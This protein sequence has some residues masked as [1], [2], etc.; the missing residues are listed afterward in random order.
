[1]GCSSAGTVNDVYT[2]LDSE[3]VRKRTDFFTDTISIFCI[4]EYGGGDNAVTLNGIVRQI[5]LYNPRTD[6][7]EETNRVL[8][9]EELVPGKGSTRKLAV[10]FTKLDGKGAT[11]LG[12][13]FPYPAGNF[14]C[15]VSLDGKPAG[16]YPFT[17]RFAPCPDGVVLPGSGCAGFYKTND[18]CPKYGLTSKDPSKVVCD[19]ATGNWKDL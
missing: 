3:G 13:Q 2:A 17:V 19:G 12:A 18:S 10:P 16:N 1:M 14:V 15:E 6:K 4:V 11:S 7:I 9:T 8:A 5:S